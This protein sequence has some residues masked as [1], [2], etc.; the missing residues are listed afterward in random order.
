MDLREPSSG[1]STLRANT[2]YV[3]GRRMRDAPVSESRCKSVIVEAHPYG[4][5]DLP[6]RQAENRR[7]RSCWLN[8][9]DLEQYGI[10][11]VQSR[12]IAF[13]AKEHMSGAA[14]AFVE[15]LIRI[16]LWFPYPQEELRRAYVC[17][18]SLVPPAVEG[19]SECGVRGLGA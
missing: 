17:C 3:Q 16:G 5:R 4:F 18:A 7:A 8:C 11:R 14:A 10:A 15:S 9:R 12:K 19:N 1:G 6:H 13:F 2:T